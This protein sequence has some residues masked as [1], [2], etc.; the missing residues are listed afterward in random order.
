MAITVIL[1]AQWG[2]EGKG[3]I[4]D[5]LAAEADLVVRFGGGDNAGHTV[6]V[7]AE[8]F[9]LHLVPSGILYPRVRCLLGA[10]MVVN[11]KKLL[12]EMDGLAAR[13]V[14][15]SP[16]RLRLGARAHLIMPYH[17]A[18]DGA[19]EAA[20]GRSAIGTTQRGI[21]PAYTDKAARSGI[22]AG[23]LLHPPEELA[24]RIRERVKEKNILLEKVYGQPS[25][26]AAAI[27]DE[28][29]CYARR[30]GPHVTDVVQ[31]L[32]AALRS[33]KRVLAEGAQGTLLDLDLGTY[34]FVTSSHPTIGGVMAGLGL[35]PHHVE[36]IVGV[37]KAYQTRVGAGP[38]PTELTGELGDRLRGTGTQPWDEYGTTTGRPRRCGWLDGVTLRHAAHVNGLTE[39]AVTKLDVLS[40]IDPLQV[41]VAYDLEEQRI[42][43]LPADLRALAGC[44]PVYETMPGWTVDIMR[45]RTFDDLPA[46]ARDY[47]TFIE[48][49]VDAPATLISVGPARDQTIRR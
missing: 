29:L 15:V 48:G 21:G 24:R 27:V 37:V 36:R 46:Q 41:C 32:A 49:L 43:H 25:L 7:G 42:E 8:R 39:F 40:G 18:L 34:P 31:E 35:G 12:A 20:R 13:G 38:M 45:A 28:Y 5:M 4:T 47:V 19:A 16:E 23:D 44:R 30:L 33:R 17:I 6:T 10:G 14:D 26:D 9:A 22:R 1:G 3:K 11:P 2:D